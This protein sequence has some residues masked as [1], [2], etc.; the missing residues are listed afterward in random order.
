MFCAGST[1]G[2][3]VANNTNNSEP[4]DLALDSNMNLYIVTATGA[5]L[6]YDQL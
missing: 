6:K 5:V 2:T 4:R 1:I 3:V